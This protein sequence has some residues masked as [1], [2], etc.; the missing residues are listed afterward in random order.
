MYVLYLFV[1]CVHIFTNN[2]AHTDGS[3]MHI[4]VCMYGVSF[5]CM[6]CICLHVYAY[7]LTNNLAHIDGS[8]MYVCVCTSCMYIH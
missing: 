4:S 1:C 5:I 7:T 6:S 2:F 8:P 3:P